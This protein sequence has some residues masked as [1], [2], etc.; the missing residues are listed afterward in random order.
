MGLGPHRWVKWSHIWCW[1]MIWLYEGPWKIS[2]H[3][4]MPS[5]YF[6][7]NDFPQTGTLK[8][9]S[10]IFTRKIQLNFGMRQWYGQEKLSKKFGVNQAKI[11]STCFAKCHLGQNRKKN[12]C[13]LSLMMP[14][15]DFEIFEEDMTQKIYENYLGIIG[16]T[17]I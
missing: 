5:L 4:D 3:L 12:I 2:T 7:H 6:L 8:N 15:K 17:E 1:V 9:C 10:G 13:E 16:W 14:R 11:N